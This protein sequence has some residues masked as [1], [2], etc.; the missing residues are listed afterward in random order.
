MTDRLA[1]FLFHTKCSIPFYKQTKKVSWFS[2]SLVFFLPC[3]VISPRIAIFEF[4]ARG[5]DYVDDSIGLLPSLPHS[6]SEMCFI[7][8]RGGPKTFEWNSPP[9]TNPQDWREKKKTWHQSQV[10]RVYTF[11]KYCYHR[12]WQAIICRRPGIWIMVKCVNFY[13][14]SEAFPLLATLESSEPECEQLSQLL[15]SSAFVLFAC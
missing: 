7:G 15:H 12:R 3:L 14:P 1:V 13:N 10:R 5:L 6:E 8:L 9:T 2:H 11:G 4:V